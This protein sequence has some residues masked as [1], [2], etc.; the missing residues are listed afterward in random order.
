MKK[1]EWMNQTPSCA[2]DY[3]PA[4]LSVA[5]AQRRILA[6]VASIE[7]V[8]TLA[9]RGALGRV[10]ARDIRAPFSVPPDDNAAMDGYALRSADLPVTGTAVLRVLGTAW[11]GKPFEGAV[12]E[13]TC[14]RIMTGAVIPQGADTVVMQ[15]HVERGDETI[16]L[17][18][19]YSAGANVRRAG[20]DLQPGALV[21]AAGRRLMPADLGLI[22]SLGIGE[23]HACRRL[24]VAFF[25]TGD[26]L[27]SI[28][29]P[30]PRGAI[31]GSNRYT[32]Y[33]MLRRLG[34]D[35]IDLGN[36]G[37]AAEE[38]QAALTQAAACADVV[39]TSG[40]ASVGDADLVLDTLQAIGRLEFWK[41]AMKPGRPVVFGHIRDAVY[42][43]LPG[44][45]VSVMATFYQFVQPALQTMMGETFIE[46]LTFKARCTSRF[47]KKPGRVEYQRGILSM[48][49]DG[50]P[51]VR[52]TGP[53]GSGILRSMSEANCFVVLPQDCSAVEAGSLVEVQ[54]FAAFV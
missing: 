49:R 43:G 30:L 1:G 31:Y 6:A 18:S 40:G 20:E 11:A 44:N 9:L 12:S 10:L 8:E 50:Q 46:K 13:K 27:R 5:E 2:D 34:A 7:G 54:P 42:F 37:D 4:A 21:L 19:G 51:V 16:T 3:D 48:D 25:S 28:G 22:A 45:P 35:A 24:R 15:E 53:Q 14:V 47:K 32:L 17:G 36:V 38:L 52:S 41:V 39:I 33:G 23:V 29:E 26:E